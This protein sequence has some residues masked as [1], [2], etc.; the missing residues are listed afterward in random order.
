[1]RILTMTLCLFLVACGADIPTDTDPDTD[2]DTPAEPVHPCEAAKVDAFD[3]GQPWS[4]D[5]VDAC[6]AGCEDAEASAA[7]DQG[8][9]VCIQGGEPC[10]ECAPDRGRGEHYQVGYDAC[11]AEQYAAGYADEGCDDG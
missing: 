6:Y 11:F 1:M 2:T 5:Q 8:R 3:A 4:P 9:L 7:Y 10:P